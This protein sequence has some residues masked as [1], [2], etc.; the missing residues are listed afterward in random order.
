MEQE[1]DDIDRAMEVETDDYPEPDKDLLFY[2]Y[3]YKLWELRF[4]YK[5]DK[6]KS[7]EENFRA[8]VKYNYKKSLIKKILDIKTKYF[9]ETGEMI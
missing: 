8:Y 5:E 7:F 6:N 3:R 2:D 1:M 4:D 9:Y